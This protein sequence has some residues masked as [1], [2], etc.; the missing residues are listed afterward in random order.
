MSQ[1]TPGDVFVS[2]PLTNVSLAYAQSPNSF[3]ADR[4]FPTI[5][6][7]MQAGIIWEWDLAYLLKNGMK[8][9]SPN[10]QSEGI[11]NKLNQKTFNAIVAALHQ[12]IPDQR[13]ANEVSPIN[14]DRAATVQLTQQALQYRE[15][16]LKAKAFATG[17]WTGFTDGTGVSG[18]PGANQ[19]KQWDQASSTPVKDVTSLST[20]LKLATG[21]RPNK[22]A[23]GRPVW[24]ALKTNPD[25]IDRIK[26]TSSPGSPAIV[27]VQ[28]V[29]ALFELEDILVSDVVQTTSAEG[30]ATNTNAFVIGKEFVLFYT[31]PAADV[32][33]P[34]AGYTITWDGYLGATPLGTRIKKFRMEANAADRI[35]IEQAYDQNLLS[36]PLG[37]YYSSVVA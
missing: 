34:S 10:S 35:E 1:P 7:P 18:V 37:G 36:S 30:A 17:K 26:Y 15:I 2:Q 29:A 23:M 27:T 8:P 24:D 32:D 20:T 5:P 16:T 3:I 6:S 14:A 28:A 13:R 31:P 33:T 9:R 19:I 22:I 11:G 21:V 25:I 12:D 4:M